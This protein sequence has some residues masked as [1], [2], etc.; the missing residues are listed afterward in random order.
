MLDPVEDVVECREDAAGRAVGKF[1]AQSENG[2]RRKGGRR[3]RGVVVASGGGGA[4][5]A[6]VGARRSTRGCCS[7]SGVTKF[8]RAIRADLG[9][10]ADDD[11][12]GRQRQEGG[13][14]AADEHLQEVKL[15]ELGLHAQELHRRAR[16]HDHPV[17]ITKSGGAVAMTPN[18]CARAANGLCLFRVVRVGSHEGDA[19]LDMGE[20]RGIMGLVAESELA[21]KE[22]RHHGGDGDD[23]DDDEGEDDER[24]D[25]EQEATSRRRKF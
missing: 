12:A 9:A 15:V 16:N 25:E 24:E 17:F 4:T 19:A 3:R 23:S 2:K 18:A 20:R 7:Q 21:R 11:G 13:A 1:V 22:H 10:R 6:M 14:E 8:R 5:T